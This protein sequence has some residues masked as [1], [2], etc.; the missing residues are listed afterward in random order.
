MR[1]G[2]LANRLGVSTSKIRYLE[3]KGLICPTRGHRNRYRTYDEESTIRLSMMLQAQTLGF[4]LK[5]IK[6]AFTANRTLE[7]APFIARL[8]DKL[9]EVA[10]HIH[11][12]QALHARLILAIDEMRDR[13]R[14][15]KATGVQIVAP[16][17]RL[18]SKTES[19]TPLYPAIGRLGV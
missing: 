6:Q 2:D 4:T 15:W 1:I 19:G 18:A 12:A 14:S 5:E 3:N 7:C 8:E 13:E 11:R 9:N 17:S 10:I 16:L